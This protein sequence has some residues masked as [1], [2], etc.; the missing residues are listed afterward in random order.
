MYLQAFGQAV[1]ATLEPAHKAPYT[2]WLRSDTPPFN[3]WADWWVS[4]GENFLRLGRLS[5]IH[6]PRGWRSSAS[7]A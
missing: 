5:I 3:T 4:G 1:Y 6:T 7:T 2:G